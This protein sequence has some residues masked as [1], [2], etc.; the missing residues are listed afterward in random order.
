MA[1][2]DDQELLDQ[3]LAALA[4]EDA[5]DAELEAFEQLAEQI[6]RPGLQDEILARYESF[7]KTLLSDSMPTH[8]DSHIVKRLEP[9]LG[10]VSNVR[11]HTGDVAT[12]AAQAM[13]AHAF[14][15]GDSDIFIDRSFFNPQTKEG[16]SLLAHEIAHTRDAA[17]GFALS[18]KHGADTSAR[19]QFAHEVAHEFAREWEVDGDDGASRDEDEST[20]TTDPGGMPREP[21][22][23]QVRLA[24]M[25]V[26]VIQKQDRWFSDRIGAWHSSD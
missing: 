23:D 9:F 14:A 15:V 6:E 10:D 4:N 13:D 24:E 26:E 19:E 16:G 17:T 8:L 3:S 11:V 7:G 5:S 2:K 20:P 1:T 25:I 22:V 21:N 12:Q 18:S